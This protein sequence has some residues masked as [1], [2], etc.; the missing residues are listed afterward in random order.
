MTTLTIKGIEYNIDFIEDSHEYYVNGTK[1][2]CVSNY[3]SD[4]LSNNEPIPEYAMPAVKRG[5]VFHKIIAL[6]LTCGVDIQ[7]ID[8]GLKG[9][10]DS[11]QLFKSEHTLIPDAVEGIIYNPVENVCMTLDYR[12]ILDCSKSL[13]DWKTGGMYAKY[14]AQLGGYYRGAVECF[15]FIP[16][17][18]AAVQIFKNGKKAKVHE[19]DI[20]DCSHR[21]G[22]IHEVYNMRRE[23]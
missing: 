1:V 2:P 12:G 21:W 3:L 13:V 20:N 6:D 7:S 22:S 5:V 8:E 15:G 4:V 23:R 14:R 10:W 11:Y 18:L 19:Y 9:Y 17:L 16:E